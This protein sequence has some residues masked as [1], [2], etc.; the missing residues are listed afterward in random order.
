MTEVTIVFVSGNS[1]TITDLGP[2]SIKGIVADAMNGV[3]LTQHGQVES[4]QI[5]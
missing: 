3:Y 1:F 2:E 5:S 4:I